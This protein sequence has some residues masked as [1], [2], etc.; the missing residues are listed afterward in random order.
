MS[1]RHTVCFLW[2][3]GRTEWTT[4]LKL[5]HELIVPEYVA[6]S[7]FF[8]GDDTP[9]AKWDED[10]HLV[11]AHPDI[12]NEHHFQQD[13]HDKNLYRFQKTTTRKYYR[14]IGA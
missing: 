14:R 5:G 8:V 11:H 12:V 10:G 1:E 2:P 9:I 4:V 6:P 7:C 3:D 13:A